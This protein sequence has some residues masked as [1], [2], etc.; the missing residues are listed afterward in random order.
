MIGSIGKKELKVA[1]AHD[2]LTDFGGA[3]RV[4]KVLAE[5]F[6][7]AP[8]YTLLYDREKFPAWLE[9]R[10]V[11]ASF[12]QHW[13]RFLR[14]RKKWLL[15]FLP[16]APE[17]FNLRDF[18][19]VI[20]SS[21]AW[22]KGIVTRLDTIHIAYLHSPMR[23]AWDAHAGY[24]NDQKKGSAVRFCAR[25][26]LN[27]IRLWDRSAADRPEHLVVNSQYTR[28]RIRKYYGRDATVIYPPVSLRETL[29]TDLS[30]A[31]P[32]DKKTANKEKKYFLTVSRL[33][34]Y[35]RI[36]AIIEAFNKLELPLL[37]VGT[38]V[39]EKHLRSIANNN[40]HF[41][42]FQPDDKLPEIYAGARAFIFAATDDFG[43]APV[44]AMLSGV[45]VLGVR[46]GGMKEIVR[47]GKDG[48]FFDAATPELIA[49]CVRRFRENES[50]YDQELIRA[51]AREFSEERFRREFE[52]LIEKAYADRG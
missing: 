50:G 35:K 38:G 40:I 5:M 32:E 1:L 31:Q 26:L 10:E 22:S 11:R 12:L 8:I 9:K 52:A 13:P 23:F 7:E 39:Q 6:P 37:V 28:E 4:L 20:S 33:S 3:E 36:E 48:E 46:Q 14:R 51:R 24:L 19:L 17:T 29:R 16:V 44:E 27:Y 30:V 18:D 42:G 43:I 47:A 49:D 2:F 41:S 21:G 34:P 15:P 45:P 25:S